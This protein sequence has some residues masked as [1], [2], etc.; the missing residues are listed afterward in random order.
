MRCRGQTPLK[1]VRDVE[2][3]ALTGSEEMGLPVKLEVWPH[4]A[5]ELDCF[6]HLEDIG[7]C[8]DILPNEPKHI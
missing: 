5:S 1:M 6:C 3:R 7:K 8:A 4:L 2:I